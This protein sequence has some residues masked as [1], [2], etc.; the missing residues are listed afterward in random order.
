MYSNRGVT[1]HQKTVHIVD[2]LLPATLRGL[3]WLSALPGQSHFS[4]STLV[5]TDAGAVR[6]SDIAVGDLVV[7]YHE[8]IGKIGYPVTGMSLHDQVLL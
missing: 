6:I 5:W 1:K 4:D 2:S 3:F 7:A 8:A